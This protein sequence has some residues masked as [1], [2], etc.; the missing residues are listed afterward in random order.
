MTHDP[1]VNQWPN[2]ENKIKIENLSQSKN[3]VRGKLVM[4]KNTI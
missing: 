2:R 4:K 3:H 1:H